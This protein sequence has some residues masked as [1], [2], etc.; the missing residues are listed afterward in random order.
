MNKYQPLKFNSVEALLDYITPDELAI[1]EKLRS[2]VFEFIP[3]I[4]EKLSFNVPF[5]SRYYQICFI[6]PASVPWGGIKQGVSFGITQG[7]LFNNYNQ[8]LE[9]KARKKVLSRTFLSVAEIDYMQLT[10]VLI[11]SIE[12]DDKLFLGKRN[13]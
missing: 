10:D 2:V 3:E 8:Y 1:V 7:H 13:R 5:Y 9:K 12:I 6:W 11:Q 4:K